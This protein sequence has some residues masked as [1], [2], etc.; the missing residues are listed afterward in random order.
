M[1]DSELRGRC[2]S[3]F[4]YA[5]F[6]SLLFGCGNSDQTAIQ[7]PDEPVVQ[8]E[9]LRDPSV[10]RMWNELLLNAIRTDF[11]RPTVHARN[12]FHISSAMFDA[13]AAYS[14]TASPYLLGNQIGNFS[15][16]FNG[17]STQQ[18][19]HLA[20]EEAISYAA[21]RL[22]THRFSDS[23]GVIGVNSAADRLME[24]LGFDTS[25]VSVDFSSGSAAS[26]GNHIADCYIQY[27][28]QDG[29]NEANAYVN[30]S[31][32]PVNPSIE[33]ELPGNPNIVNLDRWQPISLTLFIDQAG[34]PT[35]NEPEFLSPEW[36]QVASFSLSDTDR[37]IYQRDGFDYHIYYDPG[38]PPTSAGPLWEEYKWGFSLV[39]IW[40]SHLDSTDGVMMDISPN[41]LGNIQQYPA[42]FSEYPQFFNT[43]AGGDSS[44]GYAQNP[45][46]GAPY[47]EQLV[48][49]GDYAR[50]L[51]E[52]WADGPDSETPP[53]HWFVILNEVNDHPDLERRLGGVGKELGPLEW[54]V[55]GYF[56]LAG[57]M[58]DSAIAAWGIKGWY[59]YIR[60]LSAIRGMADRGQSSDAFAISYDVDGIPLQPGLI[61]IV[62]AGDPL[63]GAADEHVGK[64]K[65]YAW[66]GPDFIFNP[67][68]DTAGVDW[69]LAENWW[70]YQRP[71]FVTPPFAGYVSGHSTYSRAGAEVLTALTGSEYFPG[72]MSSFVIDAN[73]FLVFEQGPSVDMELQW[74]TYRD[75][76]DQCSL[77]RIWGGIHPPAD[78][79]PGRLIGEQIGRTAFSLAETYVR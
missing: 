29:A 13:W 75:A 30:T 18:D 52:F 63:A 33:P 60:P 51:A 12:L 56:A 77:S 64:I 72:G 27:G 42:N 36:G 28:L 22:V 78:D 57:A 17:V 65:L 49:R 19:V 5:L 69:I 53:G 4:F 7:A 46:T 40:S 16:D 58:H 44:T 34:N 39:S 3:S 66:R 50:V 9:D 26:I 8:T 37:T 79:I 70:P 35:T 48:P 61:E 2:K 59:D 14:S 68:T 41:N 71:S 23:P 45:V 20:R 38:M 1:N 32:T 43:L 25:V 55:F 76:S 73:D 31:Y 6:L 47:E 62:T 74:A 21:Y 24:A 10:A 67:N 11:A 54:D 15:C